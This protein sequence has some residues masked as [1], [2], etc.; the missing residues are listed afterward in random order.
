MFQRVRRISVILVLILLVAQIA[1]AESAKVAQPILQK[2]RY[3][4]TEQIFRVVFDVTELPVLTTNLAEN[5]DQLIVNFANIINQSSGS[6][7][8]FKDPVVSGLQITADQ[9]GK[10]RIAIKLSKQVAYKVFTLKNPN[11]VVIDIKKSMDQKFEE[12]IAPGVKHIS[13]LRDSV[14]GPISAHIVDLKLGGEYALKPILSNDAIFGLEKLQS[15]AERNNAIAAVNAS[16]FSL[17]G[18]IIGLMKM[19][20]EIVSTSDIAR[21]G[22]GILPDGKIIIDQIDSN[23]LIV[24]PDGRTVAITGVNHERGQNDLILYNN[25]Y[26]SMTGT[27]QF[28]TD[29]I[30]SNGKIVGIGHGNVAIPPGGLVLSAHGTMEKALEG[31]KAGDSIKIMQTMGELWDK[32]SDAVGAGPRLVKNGSVFLTSK[33]EEFPSDIT[34]GRAPRT[35][36]GFTKDGHVILATVDGRQESS[37]GMTLLE[38]ALFMQEWGAVEAMNLDGGGSSEMVIKGKILNKPSDG[39]ERSVGN[40]LAI[41]PKKK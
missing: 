17:N 22:L 39:R 34:T 10:P 27:N 26:D 20:G 4:Q 5:P 19:D 24:L 29:Y 41:V 30:I 2:I 35:A 21:T 12:Q 15:M 13:L 11:R 25:Y 38:L 33:V 23:N 16:Y 7:M 28:G 31:L 14:A 8:I 36:V 37:I 9:S 1:W 18:E 3:S 6:E 40:A 32:T